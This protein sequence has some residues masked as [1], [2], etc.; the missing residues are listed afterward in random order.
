MNLK[1]IAINKLGK[2]VHWIDNIKNIEVGKEYKV[3][4]KS[5]M[6]KEEIKNAKVT[7]IKEFDDGGHLI[8][9]K[10]MK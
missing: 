2:N 9:Y 8:T 4:F 5:S 7:Q 3:I 1:E 6:G 10:Y